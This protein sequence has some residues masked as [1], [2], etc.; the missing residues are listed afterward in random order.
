MSS[1][2]ELFD[3]TAPSIVAFILKNKILPANQPPLFPT[4]LGTGFFVHED[5]LVATNRHVIE[6]FDKIPNNPKTGE[7]GFAAILFLPG[8]PQRSWQMLRLEVKSWGGLSSFTSSDDWYGESVPDIGFVQ[9]RVRGVRPLKLATEDSYLRIGMNV[10]TSGYP[11]GD[12]PLTVMG[13]LNQVTPFL[14][15]GVVS[16]VFPFPTKLPH[17]FTIDIMQQGGSSG[18]PIFDGDGMVVGMMASSIIDWNIVQDSRLGE[19]QIP[20]N[21][22]ISIAVAGHIIKLAVDESLKAHPLDL[23]GI[24]SLQELREQHPDPHKSTGL[25]WDRWKV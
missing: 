10:A 5:G 6:L 13:R 4:I 9:L 24:S 20:Q 1:L 3:A 11:M 23:T 8:T 2:T 18:S 21:T 19:F 16:S 12:L 15:H 22:N 14:R 25:T 7:A 17:G